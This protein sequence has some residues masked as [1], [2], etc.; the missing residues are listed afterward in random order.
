MWQFLYFLPLPH[1]Q[2]SLRPTFSPR[3]RIGSG[4][5]S[6]CCCWRWPRPAG[7]A[8]P[9][10][11]RRPRRRL[12]GSWRRS[13]TAIPGSLPLFHAEDGVGHLVLHA[14]PHRVEFLHAL[15]LVHGLRVFLGVAAQADARRRWS[16]VYRWFFQAESSWFSSRLRSIRASP[17]GSARRRRSTG[18]ARAWSS[19]DARQRPP[20][21]PPGSARVRTHSA[22]SLASSGFGQAACRSKRLLE[23]GVDRPPGLR[24]G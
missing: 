6:P 13:P 10:R 5:L 17:G 11:R 1:G 3:L 8:W 14:L 24:A 20:R 22:S 2:G 19:V 12:R 4:F 7:R 15:P 9:R 21:A 18:P 16:I 23:L